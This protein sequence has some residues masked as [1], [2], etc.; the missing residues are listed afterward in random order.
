MLVT[1]DAQFLSFQVD[2]VCSSLPFSIFLASADFMH[3]VKNKETTD[4][5]PPPKTNF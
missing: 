2:A 4:N 3:N 5:N 1:S